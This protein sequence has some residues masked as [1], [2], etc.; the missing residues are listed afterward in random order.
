MTELRPWV[1]CLPFLE[2]G[3]VC[4][5]QKSC[6]FVVLLCCDIVDRCIYSARHKSSAI[7]QQHRQQN[8]DAVDHLPAWSLTHF[9]AITGPCTFYLKVI[10]CSTVCQLA[11]TCWQDVR[12]PYRRLRGNICFRSKADAR[13]H[14]VHKC[15]SFGHRST[16]PPLTHFRAMFLK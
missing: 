12:T 7:L 4:L 9:P 8:I 13:V 16:S 3:V 11:Q 5:Q 1:W 6:V 10:Y 2:H 14:G 15:T